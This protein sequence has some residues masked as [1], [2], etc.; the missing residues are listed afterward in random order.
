MIGPLFSYSIQLP[1][2]FTNVSKIK[3]ASIT[4]TNIILLLN[5]SYKV[6]DGTSSNV[7]AGKRGMAHMK[8][9]LG[10]KEKLWE[11]PLFK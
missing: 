9:Y 11:T 7:T 4:N 3:L 8:V 5:E 1:Y 6:T 2:G 10:L